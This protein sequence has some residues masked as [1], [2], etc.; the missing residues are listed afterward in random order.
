MYFNISLYSNVFL[1][2]WFSLSQIAYFGRNR[3]STTRQLVFRLIKGFIFLGF[4]GALITLI[5]VPHMTFQD[6]IV[7]ILAFMPTGWGLLQV[8]SSLSLSHVSFH[9]SFL[10]IYISSNI[11]SYSRLDKTIYCGFKTLTSSFWYKSSK[12]LENTAIFYENLEKE[13]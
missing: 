13:A 2:C 4:L 8:S 1:L 12:M 11:I 5:A 7:C 3:Y 9:T 6:I 10:C